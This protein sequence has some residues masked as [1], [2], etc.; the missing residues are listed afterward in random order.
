MIHRA[1]LVMIL[2][3]LHQKG[4]Y[5]EPDPFEIE[6]GIMGWA[7]GP[8][9]GQKEI[10]YE[11]LPV[12]PCVEFVVLH[13]TR[14]QACTAITAP[15]TAGVITRDRPGSQRVYGEL[16]RDEA[17]CCEKRLKFFFR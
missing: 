4:T 14:V 7:P 1:E 12:I 15:V 2:L 9:T 10:P 5:L 8:L 3:V 17:I 16:C 6:A 13:R 11:G